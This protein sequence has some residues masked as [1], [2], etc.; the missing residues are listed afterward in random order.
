[1]RI[2][3]VWWVE[4]LL[5]LQC[6]GLTFGVLLTWPTLAL[7]LVAAFKQLEARTAADRRLVVLLQLVAVG[8]LA[9]QMPGL[10]PSLLQL[11][12][13]LLSLAGLL[14]FELGDR[15]SLQQLLSR[16][17]Q[18]AAAALPLA[19]VLFLLVPRMAPLWVRDDAM[20]GPAVSGLSAE[21]DP[22][23]ISQLALSDAPAARVAFSDAATARGADRYWRVMVQSRFDGRRW[24]RAE[25]RSAGDALLPE[26][27]APP[28]GAP[29]QWW[30]IEPS[31]Q[32][33]VPWD[34]RSQPASPDLRVSVSGELRL[35]QTP[36][37]P[38]S[39]RLQQG[40]A[41]RWPL[42]PPGPED[43]AYPSGREP[44]LEALAARWRALPSDQ[45]RLAAAE[46]WFR[47]QPFT[48]TLEPGRF[49]ASGGLDA[50]LFE[51]QA[52]FCG[53]YASAFS[54]LMR[55][56]GVPARVVSGYRGGRWVQPLAA[57]A[58]LDL[59]QSDA[60]AWSEV[61]LEGS[62]WQRVDPTGWISQRDA[63]TAV[64]AEGRTG[65]RGSG[66]LQSW[67]W[68]QWQWWG[69]DLAWTSWWLGF[70]GAGPAA[71]LQRLFGNLGGGVGLVALAAAAL[72]L[73][74]GL[75]GLRWSSGWRPLLRRD[76]QAWSLQLLARLGSTPQPGDTFSRLCRRT[77]QAQP[78]LAELLLAMAGHQQRLSCAPLSPAQRSVEQRLWRQQLRALQRWLRRQAQ[79]AAASTAR[80]PSR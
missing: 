78:E 4:L 31:R 76:L 23:A 54:A 72:A 6:P 42:L 12:T 16:S 2:R 71:L 5:A 40:A 27:P 9:A 65:Q 52:G 79:P 49:P 19:L 18:L 7:V 51:R 38:R 57:P 43:L 80:R 48:Y 22:L 70:D 28:A 66:L 21:L 45:A 41:Q 53:H 1:M 74:L 36:A 59:R 35:A 37:R 32:R 62:G 77:A 11:L 8:L 47:S 13:A 24:Q 69:L 46:A 63:S 30:S 33:A 26:Q 29:L 50:F 25:E 60:H 17:L 39:Y 44:Q 34:G 15:R 55:A 56:A 73:V 3:L 68:L 20:A 64:A 61:W 58:Y 14:Q 75:Q 67:R 10:L